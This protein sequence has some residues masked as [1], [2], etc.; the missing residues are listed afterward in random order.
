MYSPRPSQW[1]LGFDASCGSCT[2]LAQ[3]VLVRSSGKLIGKSL[4]DPQVQAWRREALGE[5]APWAPTLF[6]VRGNRVRAWVGWAFIWRMLGLLGPIQA[7]Q[8]ARTLAERQP[9]RQ[10]HNPERRRFIATLGKAALLLLPLSGIKALLPSA[11]SAEGQGDGRLLTADECARLL[12]EARQNPE[13][14]VLSNYMRIQGYHDL[15]AH[16]AGITTTDGATSVFALPF[17]GADNQH[18]AIVGFHRINGTLVVNAATFDDSG[19]QRTIVDYHV[20]DGRVTQG[21]HFW[22]CFWACAATCCVLEGLFCRYAGPFWWECILV[23]CGACA[24]MC[25]FA[26]QD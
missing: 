17:A 5:N 16:A 13:F 12:A 2:E 9:R 21:S 24:V 7:W 19:A 10:V 8:V 15:P 3:R 20:Q 23:I 18:H 4:R 11:V 14:T 26:C 25:F 22:D 1:V 6:E